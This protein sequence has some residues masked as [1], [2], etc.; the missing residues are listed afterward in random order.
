MNPPPPLQPRFSAKWLSSLP[1]FEEVSCRQAFFNIDEDDK[2]AV[3]NGCLHGRLRSTTREYRN[4][5][6]VMINA[7]IMVETM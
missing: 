5:Y 1:A 4:W 6:P 3:Q 2:R 7:S